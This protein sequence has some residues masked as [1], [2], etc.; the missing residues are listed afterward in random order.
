MFLIL[1][2]RHDFDSLKLA[3]DPFLGTERDASVEM[4]SYERKSRMVT[5]HSLVICRVRH[6]AVTAVPYSCSCACEVLVCTERVP[7]LVLSICG[8]LPSST[9]V[10]SLIWVSK[11]VSK[12]EMIPRLCFTYCEVL[13]HNKMT[14]LLQS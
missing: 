7:L 2:F 3:G 1:R 12:R 8:E 5:A 6:H 9:T 10:R 13:V 14:T 4:N 11:D